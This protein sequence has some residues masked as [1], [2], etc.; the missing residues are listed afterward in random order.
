MDNLYRCRKP[1][2]KITHKDHLLVVVKEGGI[3]SPYLQQSI[4]QFNNV[5]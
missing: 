2:I 4:E 1:K 3:Q 5:A